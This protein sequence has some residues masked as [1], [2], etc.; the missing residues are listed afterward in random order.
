MKF[1]FFK[2]KKEPAYDPLNIRVTDLRQGFI[3]DYD[4]KS[5]EVVEEYTYDWGENYFSKEYKISSGAD[6]MFLSV[7]EDDVVE[8]SLQK[9][10]KLSSIDGDIESEIIRNK[11]P[12]KKIVYK[13]VAYNRDSESPGYF[14]EENSNKDW[15]ELISWTYYNEEEDRVL[16]VE[17]WGEREFEASHGKVIKEYEISGITPAG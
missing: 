2:K 1:N 17:Q 6:I 7:D 3:F 9:K 12:P 5:W 16:T 8:L 11:I 15:L 10:I 4:L 14:K 13:G